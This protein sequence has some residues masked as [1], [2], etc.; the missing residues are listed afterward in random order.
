[1]L[2]LFST[3]SNHP[4]ADPKEARVLLAELAASQAA[5]GVEE[6]TSW[7]ES[8]AA[9]ENLRLDRRIEILLQL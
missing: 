8:V 5:A 4:L 6:A 2:G 1:M 7:C 3:K 9:D